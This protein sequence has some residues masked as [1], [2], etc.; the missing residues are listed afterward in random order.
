MDNKKYGSIELILGCMFSGK[1]TE[2]IRR[3][4]RYLIGGKSCF[5]I[6]YIN[7]TR[8]NAEKVTTHDQVEVDALICEYLEEADALINNYDVICIDEL[9]F[10][11][12]GDIFVDKWANAGKIIVAC[13]LNGTFNR[14]EFPIVSRII[15][16]VEN[17]TFLTAVC[18]NTGKDASF[19]KIFEK[20]A[21]EKQTEIIGGSEAYSAVDRETY[22]KN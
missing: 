19:S 7:D 13:A 15:P 22:Y 1:T 6:K 4:K 17:I 2:L 14:T 20:P 10:Y 5:M 8:Y 11:K 9:Q 16:L 21:D 3:Y 12:D 18:K